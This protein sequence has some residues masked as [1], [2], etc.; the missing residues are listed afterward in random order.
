MKRKILS[1]P[2][3]SSVPNGRARKHPKTLLDKLYS[4]QSVAHK[5]LQGNEL[6][7]HVIFWFRSDCRT[8]DNR[9]LSAACHEAKSRMKNVIGLFVLSVEDLRLHKMVVAAKLM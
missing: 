7:E 1:S 9:G 4:A 6:A 3:I 5:Q 8:Q 2:A